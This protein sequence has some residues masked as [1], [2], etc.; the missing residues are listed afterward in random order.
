[1]ARFVRHVA[2]DKCGSSDGCAVYDDESTYCF[3]CKH[4]TKGNKL[5]YEREDMTGHID[6]SDIIKLPSTGLL[7]RGINETV[8]KQFGVRVEYDQASG[9]QKS[10]YFPLYKEGEHQGYAKRDMPKGFKQING[11]DCDPFGAHIAG[12]GGKF[13]IVTEGCEDALAAVQMLAANGKNYRVVAT[14]GTQR[15][16]QMLGYFETF[17]K[18]VIAFDRDEAGQ[19]AANEFAAALPEGKAFM[20]KWDSAHGK[21]PNDLLL[22]GKS[23]VFM[24]SIYKCEAY[25]PAGILVGEDVWEIMRNYTEPEGIPY[26]PEWGDFG[27]KAQKMRRGEISL[28]IG[29]TGCGKTSYLR[30]LKQH[31]ITTTDWRVGE[32]ELEE[33]AQKTA[34]GMMQFQAKKK[35]T[36]MTPEEKRAAFEATYGTGKLFLLDHRARFARGQSLMSK[37]KHLR[38]G[39]GCDAIFLDH[40]TLAVSEFGDGNGL[41]DQDRMMGEFLEFVE[42]SQAHLCLIS[43]LRKTGAGGNSFESGAIPRED[44][45]KGS[46]SLKQISFDIFGVSR[47]KHHEDEYERNVSQLHVL[48]CRE[49]GRTGPSDR[50]YWDDEACSLIPAA[51]PVSEEEFDDS[52]DEF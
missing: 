47:N 6:I 30:R 24:N 10:Y 20:A 50:L 41:A 40:I 5:H 12:R 43:H 25:Q 28:W 11:R 29:G 39:M 51:E 17:D 16:G 32:I 4:S 45:I 52:R 42:T 21:D 15:W 37:I 13:L 44:D 31:I 36:V 22:S 14:M 18:V 26:P 3:V 35:M 34:R 1:M 38:Y 2:C 19:Q 46:G 23:D 9:Q 48:K 27:E 33:A 8:A 49:T 7:E